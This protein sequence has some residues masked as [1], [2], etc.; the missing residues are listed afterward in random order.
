MCCVLRGWL[1]LPVPMYQL[2]VCTEVHPV[3]LLALGVTQTQPRHGAVCTCSRGAAASRLLGG[4]V[5]SLYLKVFSEPVALL[6][7][8]R[9]SD[10]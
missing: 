3:A 8:G 1:G 6:S 4:W 5:C 7:S 10:M 2:C 9:N